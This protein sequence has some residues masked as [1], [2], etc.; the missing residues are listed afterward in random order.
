MPELEF[1]VLQFLYLVNKEI[2]YFRIIIYP[3]D[4]AFYEIK[5]YVVKD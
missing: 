5:L 2:I 1:L 4:K 3:E